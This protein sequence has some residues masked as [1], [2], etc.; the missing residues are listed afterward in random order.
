V[1]KRVLKRGADSSES[2]VRMLLL[3]DGPSRI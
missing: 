2:L 3:P 1:W